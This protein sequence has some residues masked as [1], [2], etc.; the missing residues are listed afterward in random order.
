MKK[1]KFLP[2]IIFPLIMVVVLFALISGNANSPRLFAAGGI[3]SAGADLQPGTYLL[4]GAWETG[5]TGEDVC[6]SLTISVE[7]LEGWCVFMSDMG[8]PAF[9]V[10][11]ETYA[12]ICELTPGTHTLTI[13]CQESGNPDV[14]AVYFAPAE[15]YYSLNKNIEAQLTFI[16]GISFGILIYALS[17]YFQKRSE[18]YMLL[19]ALMV[20]STMG[21]S[22]VFVYPGM[23][24]SPLLQGLLLGPVDFGFLSQDLSL[25]LNALLITVLL[26]WLR[27]RLLREVTPMKISSRQY[28]LVLAGLSILALMFIAHPIPF[29]VT[30][31]LLET[32]IYVIE[33][34]CI[35]SGTYSSEG[36]RYTLGTAWALTIATWLLTNGS[37]LGIFPHGSVDRET[38][39]RGIAVMFYGIAFLMVINGKFARK[40]T[41]ADNLAVRLEQANEGLEASV[42][43]KTMRLQQSYERIQSLKKRRD[44]FMR[45][46]VHS[47]KSTLF[48]TGGYADM[49]KAELHTDL[50]AAERHLDAVNDNVDYAKQVIDDLSA[51]LALEENQSVL[52]I[53]HF[54]MEALL[55]RARET[56]LGSVGHKHLDITIKTSA[57]NTT[58]TGDEY[59]IRQAVQ[60]VLDNA[61]RH[62]SEGG[63]V[64]ITLNEDA[65]GHYVSIRDHGEGITPE[66]V[67]HIFEY[68]YSKHQNSRGSNGLGLTITKNIM[69]LHDGSISVESAPGNGALFTLFLPK[70]KY[71]GEAF[72]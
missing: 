47:L 7:G 54:D 22:L 13:R 64:E 23:S 72:D 69:E 2:F 5:E 38:P 41:E 60:N 28:N 59:R 1:S 10:D 24:N 16:A 42:R 32:V 30:R 19:L 44:E 51:A 53:E 35:A 39:L 18:R 50:G 11:G 48:S 33:I 9:E 17:L 4:D 61:V 6:L 40:F 21:R 66:E 3:V 45:G 20:Y 55:L 37:M 15:N 58:C 43:E 52:H 65:A 34:Y 31:L 36:D 26:A 56:S 68:Y 25:N 14:Y 62:S 63:A 49:A 8:H 46:I 70:G 29:E 57:K 67:G 12:A 71:D 27:Y